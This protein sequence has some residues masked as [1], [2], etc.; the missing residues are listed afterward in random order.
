METWERDSDSRNE[1]Y[2]ALL[3]KSWSVLAGTGDETGACES[4]SCK[5]IRRAG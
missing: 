1:T 2:R 5:V 3:D 4:A